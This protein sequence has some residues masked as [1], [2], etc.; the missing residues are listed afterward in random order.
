[1]N[2]SERIQ[3]YLVKIEPSVSGQGGHDQLFKAATAL[4]GDWG[5]TKGEAI[6]FLAAWNAGCTP[7]WSERDLSHKLDE[8]E[9]L[10]DPTRRGRLAQAKDK[11][12]HMGPTEQWAALRGFSLGLMMSFGAV[13]L[14]EE[15]FTV[16]LWMDGVE[17][18]RV[19]RKGDNKQIGQMGKTAIVRGG[20]QGLYL[21]LNEEFPAGEPILVVEGLP[22]TLRASSF[23]Y[24]AVGLFSAKPAKY[25]M[26][27]LQRLLGGREVIL[28]PQ[29]DQTGL[30]GMDAVARS[31]ANVRCELRWVPAQD[32]DLDDRIKA[33]EK[34][35]DLIAAAKPWVDPLLPAGSQALPQIMLGPDEGRVV[36]AVITALAAGD[37][38]LYAR[39]PALVSVIDSKICGLSQPVVREKITRC[40]R[41]LNHDGHTHPP[42]WLA[43]NIH[44]RMQWPVIRKLRGVVTH[45]VILRD[46]TILDENGYNEPSQLLLMMNG[47]EFPG[48]PE[49]PNLDD[50]QTAV[51][52]LLDVIVDFPF[53]EDIHRAAWIAALL[54]VLARHAFEGPAPMMIVDKNI[55]GAGASLL[56]DM[57]SLI[58]KGCE[59]KHMSQVR[60][61]EEQR[62][63]ITS[64]LI[65]GYP[66]ALIDNLTHAIGGAS[67]ETLLTSRTWEDRILSRSEMTGELPALTVWFATGNNVQLA[68][69]MIRRVL[70]IRMESAEENPETRTNFTHPDIRDYVRENRGALLAAGLT[71][72]RGYMAAGCPKQALAAWGSYEDWTRIVRGSCVW[73]GLADPG[74][75]RLGLAQSVDREGGALDGLLRGLM[76]MFPGGSKI[77]VM[78][79]M[80]RLNDPLFSD[81]W[82][83]LRRAVME[84]A[85]DGAGRLSGKILAVKFRN[86]RGRVS[87]GLRLE[88]EGEGRKCGNLWKVE[89][90][91]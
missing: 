79:V 74:E 9:K 80:K 83:D 22:D 36:D 63:Q 88:M 61:D 39:G 46:G 41:L 38:G 53:T 17:V 32:K 18:G 59:M 11:D 58:V 10:I 76:E 81:S 90:I 14:D 29:P 37:P 31:L 82:T 27:E 56:C 75:T 2:L 51:E 62:K 23:G 57:I 71:I 3:S 12:I 73:A 21:K 86:F 4:V 49:R 13:D 68:G 66:V 70:H 69:D 25:L 44:Q 42:A 72:L 1:M 7:P 19:R 67:L 85:T 5:L 8:A 45:P 91:N 87:D 77:T 65:A 64:I 35:D 48:V 20:K 6:P 40:C 33:G 28:F 34:L 15:I 50:V 24:H 26:G 16:P 47:L 43:P 30:Q 54:T 60:D 55:R 52:M 84:L 78:E 89:K